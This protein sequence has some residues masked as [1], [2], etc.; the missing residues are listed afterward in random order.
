M[1]V[2]N[3]IIILTKCLRRFLKNENKFLFLEISILICLI[4]MHINL[5]M[6]FFDSLASNSIIPYI[7][8]PTR[9]TS[10]SRTL[11][12]KIF[13]NIL[14][15]QIISGNLTAIISD[16]LPQF[17]FAPSILSNPPYNISNIFGKDWSKFD[18]GNFILDYFEKKMV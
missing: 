13:S 11:I 10:H 14:S 8:Q 4:I 15:S 7:M 18:K 16:H 6:I 17:L 9:L 12:D 3:L 1:D 5:L 2:Q